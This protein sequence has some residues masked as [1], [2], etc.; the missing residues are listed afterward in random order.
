MSEK[1]T[2]AVDK[3]LAGAIQMIKILRD[4]S[5][6][7][8]DDDV[9]AM[10]GVWDKLNESDKKFFAGQIKGSALMLAQMSGM[11]KGATP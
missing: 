1:V 10:Y 8:V 9:S 5:I 4:C 7:D 11:T 2:V 3:E 6:I